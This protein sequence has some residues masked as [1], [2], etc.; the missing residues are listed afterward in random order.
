SSDIGSDGLGNQE[1]HGRNAQLDRDEDGKRGQHQHGGYIVQG[2]GDQPGDNHEEDDNPQ[3]VPFGEFRGLDGNI[4][5]KARVP[6]NIHDDHH[7]DE[8]E[9]DFQVDFR[10]G[11]VNRKDVQGNDE[12]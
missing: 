6:H 2:H 1:W 10:V 5:K 8:Q 11:D 3:R 9:N 4:L 12:R 7:G